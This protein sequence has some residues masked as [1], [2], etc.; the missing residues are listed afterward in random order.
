MEKTLWA[1]NNN[2]NDEERIGRSCVIIDDLMQ[3]VDEKVK[4][5]K[6]FTTSSLS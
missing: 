3:K 6:R 1:M 5:N 2:V 4:E